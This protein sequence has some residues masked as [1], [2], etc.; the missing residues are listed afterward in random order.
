[1]ASFY[2]EVNDAIDA[3]PIDV[4]DFARYH[5]HKIDKEDRK[6]SIEVKE[7]INKM[8]G[9]FNDSILSRYA[10]NGKIASKKASLL[11]VLYEDSFEVLNMMKYSGRI[12]TAD[13]ELAKW[14]IEEIGKKTPFELYSYGKNTISSA[15]GIIIDYFRDW[16]ITEKYNRIYSKSNDFDEWVRLAEANSSLMSGAEIPFDI[17]AIAEKCKAIISIAR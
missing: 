3:Q 11:F 7:L 1:M 15:Y 6:Y 12:R 16:M 4:K 9:N 14:W 10:T 17:S 13:P 2:K 5:T 8:Y